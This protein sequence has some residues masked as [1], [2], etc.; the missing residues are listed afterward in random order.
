MKTLQTPHDAKVTLR[1]PAELHE[2][3]VAA[4]KSDQRSLNAQIVWM[5]QRSL[6][7]ANR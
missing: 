4:A 2:Q 5:L 3:L 1:L 7:A 6:E